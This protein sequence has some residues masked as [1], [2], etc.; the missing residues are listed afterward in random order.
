MVAA[1]LLAGGVH[2]IPTAA[3]L[4]AGLLGFVAFVAGL[5]LQRRTLRAGL[6]VLAPLAFVVVPLL[7]SVPLPLGLRGVIDR[8]GTQLLRDDQTAP[9]AVWPLSLDPP[10]TRV[11]VG[12]AALGLVAFVV[13]F[14]LASGQKRRHWVARAIGAVGITAVVIGLGHRILGVTRLYGM[15]AV[16]P[17]SLLV[18]PFVN[19]NHTAE[20]LELAAFVCLA[21]SFQR[22]TAL[23]RIGWTVGML[24]CAGGATATLSRGAGVALSGAAATFVI[25]RYFSADLDPAGRRRAS[26]AWGVLLLGIIVLGA[27]ALGAGRIIERFKTDSVTTDVRLRLWRN[28][29]AVFVAHPMGI[30]RGA[31]SRVFPIYRTLKVPFPLRFAFLENQPLQILVDCGWLFSL[32]IGAAL[33]VVAWKIVRHGRRDKVEMALICGLVAV[34]L[35]SVVDFGLE[36]LGVLLP[37]AA[38][39]GT[40]LGRLHDRS[41]GIS[42]TSKASWA[43][44]ALAASA[45]VF[46]IA[47]TAHP[48]F[49]NFDALLKQ[50][51]PPEAQLELLHRAEAVHPLDYF[52]ALEESRFDPLRGPPGAGSPRLHALNR[53]MRLC[54]ACEAVHVAAAR[55]L[56]HMGLRPQALL[57]WRLAIDLQPSLFSATLGELYASGAKPEELAA[58]AASRADHL[59][60]LVTFLRGRNRTNDAFVV[61]GQAEALGAPRG[62]ILLARAQLEFEQHQIAQAAATAEEA[63]RLG[64]QDARLEILRARLILA[65][66]GADAADQALAILDAAAARAPMNVA[67]QNERVDLVV[68]YKKWQAAERALEGLKQALYEASGAATGAHIWAA[69]V[70]SELGR[71]TNALGEYRIA[72]ADTPNDVTLWL[73]FARAAITAGRD[74]TAR[75]ALAQASRLSPN[76]PDIAAAQ[77]ALDERQARLRASAG[78][79]VP[80]SP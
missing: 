46:G 77:R 13:A 42:W 9:T 52:Y 20:L 34:L 25:L 56:W 8:N 41:E 65:Q 35:Q 60:E 4:T 54:P 28:G 6:V 80:S 19:A 64:V 31:F 23:N 14:H 63:R 18:G 45:L 68:H 59:L 53:A 66:K 5:K 16:S 67:V 21:C 49:D 61:L 17:R 70:A 7:Q 75:E 29:L 22:P 2:R 51:R 37:F 3:L 27:G 79:A 57:E 50:R 62:E 1:P 33:V 24:L 12:R 15:L 76:S 40:V 26:I 58:V 48:S 10:E 32:L 78:M 72:L 43:L 36:T 44:P 73:E 39:L 30:G 47:S 71:W 11:D 55:S 38:C 74:D 69:R